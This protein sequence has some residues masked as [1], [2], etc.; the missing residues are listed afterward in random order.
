MNTPR[1]YTMPRP[2]EPPTIHAPFP[3]LGKT[4]WPAPLL[5]TSSRP[6][7]SAMSC[8]IAESAS[9]INWS[10]PSSLLGAVW[11]PFVNAKTIDINSK[12]PKRCFI[13][14]P[15]FR[16]HIHDMPKRLIWQLAFCW[17]WRTL[18][19]L[20]PRGLHDATVPTALV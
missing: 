3:T 11:Q 4:M 9:D 14:V 20:Q 16:E 7:S 12:E 8:F 2:Y 17:T 15:S 10:L 1:S 18:G 6:G 19:Y 13:C 5:M